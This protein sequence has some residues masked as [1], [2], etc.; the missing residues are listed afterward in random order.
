M[1]RQ[2]NAASALDDKPAASVGRG[3][4]RTSS[5]GLQLV[6]SFLEKGW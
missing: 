3:S 2:A 1:A 6:T 5:N 4:N